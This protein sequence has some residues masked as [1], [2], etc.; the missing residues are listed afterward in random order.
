[1]TNRREE[2]KISRQINL[3]GQTFKVTLIEEHK[4][5]QCNHATGEEQ[6]R[7]KVTHGLT[8]DFSE[9]DK[10][11]DN[12]SLEQVA[13]EKTTSVEVPNSANSYDINQDEDGDAE[14]EVRLEN[15]T[16][17]LRCMLGNVSEKES[18]P[19]QESLP[20]ENMKISEVNCTQNPTEQGEI[21]VGDSVKQVQGDTK[22]RSAK[23][24]G[25]K[26]KNQRLECRRRAGFKSKGIAYKR[27]T[28]KNNKNRQTKTNEKLMAPPRNKQRKNIEAEETLLMGKDLGLDPIFSDNDTLNIIIKRLRQL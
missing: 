27:A 7:H 22:L 18:M 26:K 4:K 6:Q 19:V 13:S 24:T 15:Q 28:S 20:E 12:Q 9:K 17:N 2:I 16:D 10:S 8:T 3:E 25:Y 14:N 23:K 21:V 11:W 5:F 1:M